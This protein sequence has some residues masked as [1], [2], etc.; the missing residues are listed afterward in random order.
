MSKQNDSRPLEDQLRSYLQSEMSKAPQPADFWMKLEA[1]LGAPPQRRLPALAWSRLLSSPRWRLAPAMAVAA[2][3]VV[4]ASAAWLWGVAPGDPS[5]PASTATGQQP[6]LSA[7]EPG[8]AVMVNGDPAL[9]DADGLLSMEVPLDEGQDVL[10]VLAAD[11]KD[12][13]PQGIDVSGSA[14]PVFAS[15]QADV[16]S[17]RLF[18]GDLAASRGTQTR[19]EFVTVTGRTSPDAVV[20]VGWVAADV[21]GDGAFSAE[22]PLEEGENV[23]QVAALRG[24]EEVMAEISV[25]RSAG[26]DAG[27]TAIASSDGLFVEALA[28][29]DGS[30]LDARSVTVTG[31]TKAEAFVLIG[32]QVTQAGA[33][34]TFSVEVSLEVGPNVLVIMAADDS[35][36][37]E[38]GLMLYV[39][40][41]ASA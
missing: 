26:R 38:T 35:G 21:L 34:G 36:S 15:A 22:F 28:P 30:V 6:S 37:V 11:G 39:Q 14:G 4:V 25:F 3:V 33:D 20:L 8:A 9:A 27:T 32:D 17:E 10:W 18:L 1:R 2:A 5:L 7:S 19:A 31:R 24:D 29:S 12:Q 16:P 41:R 40:P 13:A 23:F